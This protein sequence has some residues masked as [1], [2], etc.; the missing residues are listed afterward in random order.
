MA[1]TGRFGQSDDYRREELIRKRVFSILTS[2]LMVSCLYGQETG[3]HHISKELLIIGTMHE[4]P[5]IVSHSYRPLLK[6]AKNYQ[7]EAIYT[8]DIPP[9]DTLSLMNF[10]P[11]FLSIADSLLRTETID[12]EHFGDLKK[13][14]LSELSSDDYAFLAKTYL[15]KR[16][17]A[18]YSYYNYLKEYGIAGSKKPL[19]NENGDLIIPLA[20]AMGISELIPVDDHQKEKEYQRA[21]NKS[22]KFIGETGDD[23]VLSQLYKRDS[24][25]RVWPALW[26]KLGKYTNKL[27][28][29]HRYYLIN[30]CRYVGRQNESTD[31]V[32]EL[33]D[34]RNRRIAENLAAQIK[35]NPFRRNILIIGAG[36]VISV[37][38]M[39][40]Q[41]YPEL[42]VKL[43]CDK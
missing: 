4:V 21:W 25:K 10:T 6:Y 11:K 17:R 12:E 32:R 18:N 1:Y 34:G 40:K 27:E 19:R 33:W 14:R 31:A 22:M 16:D 9:K 38:E 23:A 3:E 2:V 7:P 20:I 24:R 39:L 42:Q 28:T 36:H 8:E 15:M 26:G 30:S 43:M 37:K 13:K 41:I 29:L 35:V 5:S